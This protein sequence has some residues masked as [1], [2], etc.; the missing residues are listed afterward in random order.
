MTVLA[1]ITVLTG[2][3]D[4]ARAPL[5]TGLAT[6]ADEAEVRRTVVREMTTPSPDPGSATEWPRSRR[7]GSPVVHGSMAS[8]RSVSATC[9]AA[10][11]SAR[12]STFRLI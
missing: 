4:A 1:T 11:C 12:S 9:S 8:M 10:F 7:H 3:W 5:I 6:T 2:V